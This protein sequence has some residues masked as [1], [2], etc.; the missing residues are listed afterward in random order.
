LFV[1][2][3][4]V[5]AAPDDPESWYELYISNNMMVNNVTALAG[6]ISLQ[7]ALKVS[8]IN[9]T[10]AHND[11]TATAADA[12]V[13]GDILS[14]PQPAGI[15]ARQHSIG[16]AKVTGSGAGPEFSSFS[17]PV[18]HD[19]IIYQNRSFFYDPD[20][21]FPIGGGVVP[22]PA[23]PFWDLAVLPETLGESLDP[24]YCLLTDTTGFD[25]TNTSGDPKF[26]ETY[27]NVITTAAEPTEG[28]NFIDINFR[29]LSKVGDYHIG[30]SS[31]SRHRRR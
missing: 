30:A 8:I 9:N 16:L 25:G 11:S 23:G 29:P 26:I 28:G 2:G 3:Q 22:N 13:G 20:I 31:R 14:T 6:T 5:E 15:A 1:N 7:D 17:N 4:D 24:R 27:F 10:I 21:N 18:L 19:C 12:F